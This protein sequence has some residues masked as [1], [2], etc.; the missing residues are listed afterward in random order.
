MN[1][2]RAILA[3]VLLL[4]AGS[5]SA[6]LTPIDE[7]QEY[8]PADGT[9]MSK[10]LGKTVSIQGNIFVIEGTYDD[11]SYYLHDGDA[12]IRFYQ[13]SAHSISIGNLVSATGLVGVIDGEA[14]IKV[15]TVVRES[16]GSIEPTTVTIADLVNPRDYEQVGNFVQCAGRIAALDTE[17]IWIHN[18]ADDTVRVVV[19]P[20]TGI[21]FSH[22]SLGDSVRITGPVTKDH[23][24]ILLK[25]RMQSD[26]LD[27][28][29]SSVIV[30][31]PDG[32][33]D[34][35]TIQE[36]VNA[37]ALF[38][39]IELTSGIFKGPGNRDIDMLDKGLV[40]RSRDQDPDLCIIECEGSGA[41][42]H[43]GFWFH[44]DLDRYSS[45][46]GVTIR[47]GY[48]GGGAALLLTPAIIEEFNNTGPDVTNCVFR[49]NTALSCGGALYV[50]DGGYMTGYFFDMTDCQFLDNSAAVG[51][52]MAF[53]S[54]TDY[55]I[56]GCE[57]RRNSASSSGVLSYG[58]FQH[59]QFT[60]CDFD[61]NT[62][63]GKGGIASYLM[64]SSVRYDHCT[65]SH[66]SASEGGAFEYGFDGIQIGDRRSD[67]QANDHFTD[68]VF[69]AN[70]A[71]EGGVMKVGVY[72]FP[73][74]SQCRFIENRAVNGGVMHLSGMGSYVSASGCLFSHN[75]AD[76]GG[77]VYQVNNLGMYPGMPH[78]IS[79]TFVENSAPEGSSFYCRDLDLFPEIANCI[80]AFGDSGAAFF[81]ANVDSANL[82]CC[83]IYGNSGGDYTA[84][85]DTLLGVDGNISADP[86]FCDLE[87]REYTLLLGSPCLPAGKGRSRTCG[88]IGA[89]GEGCTAEAPLIN[90]IV[91]V[92]NDQG[93]QV[94]I[95]WNRS[96]YDALGSAVTVTGYVLYR[97]EDMY[98]DDAGND[99]ILYFSHGPLSS[100]LDDW[101]YLDTI[102]ARGDSNYQ[103]VAPTLCD[104]A[105]TS[106]MCWSTFMVSTVTTHPLVYFDSPPDSGYSVDNI[107]PP[108]PTSLTVAYG[109]M[110]TLTW[111]D[112]PA[113]D[114]AWF[115]LYRGSTPE[116]EIIPDNLVHQT[117][118]LGWVDS[119][120][121]WGDHYKLLAVDDSGNLS[122]P[123]S[124]E[125][126]LDVDIQG[127]PTKT[128]LVGNTPN[129][130][131]PKTTIEFGLASEVSAH[132]RI[133]DLKGRLVRDLLNGDRMA[134]GIHRVAW[135]GRDNN[136]RFV[137]A[138]VYCYCLQTGSFKET[139]K[140]ALIR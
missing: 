24:E 56:I 127:I 125:T 62:A 58:Q 54:S 102:P 40:I 120:G 19:D 128:S 109:A 68:C 21:L 55:E 110:N 130:F 35:P 23:E 38:D 76:S 118:D 87:G 88:L 57:F 18:Q 82:S 111:G 9:P 123:T 39:I 100:R 29:P 15:P 2:T 1:M 95:D 89:Y 66:N 72:A 140:M 98:K 46:S 73:G 7:I 64:D 80:I 45:L 12:G 48:A 47:N 126:V 69:T 31:Q 119:D 53:D 81:L 22:I 94:R 33:G 37:A 91:D 137:S 131:N 78:F 101:D 41:D 122:N 107:V 139:R 61:S 34:Y 17:E 28:S 106:G 13:P 90:S 75:H 10:W 27:L 71:V 26:L 49:D 113:P 59:G 20:D 138:G 8:N 135:D 99:D 63:A 11:G 4:C 124:P 93:R 116:F 134:A 112:N 92:G 44:G 85:L 103:Y 86:L 52:A 104:S 65:F 136:G 60:D 115:N 70:Q 108:P 43:R 16:L 117:Q 133:Y 74:F 51:G 36:A 14:Y 3:M 96:V 50:G 6:Q 114:F 42:N 25:P 77:V 83:D 97:R 79:C 67:R 129:P 121:T 32:L 84:N 105:I 132:L 5:A 30:I